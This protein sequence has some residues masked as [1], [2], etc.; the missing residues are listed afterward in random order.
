MGCMK[1][2]LLSLGKE[3]RTYSSKFL[4]KSEYGNLMGL[5]RCN[6]S[7]NALTDLNLELLP[8]YNMFKSNRT[9]GK[10]IMLFKASTGFR[11]ANHLSKTKNKRSIT[12]KIAHKIPIRGKS[13]VNYIRRF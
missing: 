10:P 13:V 7:G 6:M 11:G 2:P 8:V 5:V 3:K 1:D 12:T 4:F 9:N